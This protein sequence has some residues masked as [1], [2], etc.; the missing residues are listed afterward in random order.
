[1]KNGFYQKMRIEL[2]HLESHSDALMFILLRVLASLVYL[3]HFMLR[4]MIS[5]HDIATQTYFCILSDR[6]KLD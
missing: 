4:L 6:F 2:K 3:S 1:M 5:G